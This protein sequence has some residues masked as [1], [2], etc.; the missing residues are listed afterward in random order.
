MGVVGTTSVKATK[1]AKPRIE[2]TVCVL[3]DARLAR[4]Q[5][6][7][8]AAILA[9]PWILALGIAVAVPAVLLPHLSDLVVGFV[10]YAVTGVGI[11]VGFHRHFTH[12]SFKCS[13]PL[14]AALAIGGLMAGQAPLIHWVSTHRRH[15][16]TSDTACDPHSPQQ[17]TK[18]TLGRIRGVLHAHA[19]WFFDGKTTNPLHYAPDIVR[20]SMLRQADRFYLAWIALGMAV[21]FGFG[22]IFDGSFTGGLRCLF[23]AGLVRKVLLD[24]VVFSINSICHTFGLRR[25]NTPDNSRNNIYLAIPTFGEALHN[26]HHAAPTSAI[27]GHAFWEID[28]G[29]Y[30]IR[31]LEVLRLV[32][33]VN[34]PTVELNRESNSASLAKGPQEEF[35][36]SQW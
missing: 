33:D 1:Q 8:N 35:N 25:Y 12:R 9:L 6:I 16:E 20:D 28:L 2:R 22:W 10:L 24:H 31:V 30:L 4:H 29:G 17:T 14:Q 26:N 23:W 19:G 34:R 36:S 18:G 32:W 5:N 21:P 7:H 11:D 27:F 13:R 15:H 3:R